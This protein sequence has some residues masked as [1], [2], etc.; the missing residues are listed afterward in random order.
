MGI[1]ST[2]ISESQITDKLLCGVDIIAISNDWTGDPLSKTHLVRHLAKTNRILWLNA[3]ANRRPSLSQSD[4]ARIGSKIRRFFEPVKQ[5]E[6]NIFVLNPLALPAYGNNFLIWLNQ[7]LL[8]TQIRLALRRLKFRSPINLSFNPAAGLVAR[9]LDESLL[10][11]YCADEY[12]AFTDSIKGLAQLEERL[13]RKADIVI[14]TSR[15]LL[16]SKQNL[17]K[18]IFLIPHGVDVKHFRQA[19]EPD[20]KMPDEIAR[21]PRPIIGFHGLLADW[22]DF[23]LIRTIA[24]N[25]PDASLVL[26]GKAANDTYDEIESLRLLP[27]V[28][29]LGRKA[30]SELPSYCK[31][32]DVAINPFKL[33]QLTLAANPLKVREYLAA[34][35]CVVSTNIPAVT[36]LKYCYTANTHD[37]FI[38]LILKVLELRPD[39]LEISETVANDDWSTRV[40]TLRSIVSSV[41]SGNTNPGIESQD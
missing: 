37:E 32:F 38:D 2:K 9:R 26:I 8:R 27:N 20:L 18:N 41:I 7:I 30:Y 14:V 6:N 22:I 11:Y 29:I 4:L 15:P 13:F 10:I 1:E 24:I 17:N 19:I 39:P 35:K 33:N 23:D 40:D 28:Y 25:I 12:T 21:I 16:E 31:A 36:E 5:V 3:L 34:G